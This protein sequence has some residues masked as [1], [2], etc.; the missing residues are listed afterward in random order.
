[1]KTVVSSK[2]VLLSIVL[3]MTFSVVAEDLDA[4]LEAQKKKAVRRVYSDTA[5]IETRDFLIP[6]TQSEEE[7]ALDRE[8]ERLENQLSIQV[9][10]SREIVAP[11]ARIPVPVKAEN[12]L[13]PNQ[14][15]PE[16]PE[17]LSSE[18]AAPSWVDLELE[19][20]KEIQLQKKALAEEE[21]LVNKMLREDSRKSYSTETPQ[22][23]SYESML[24]H[25]IT[26]GVSPLAPNSGLV[27]PLAS[28]RPK[29]KAPSS[30]DSL[31]SPTARPNSGVI[32]KT[33]F[34]SSPRPQTPSW[35]PQFESTAPST[36]T[37]FTSDWGIKKPEALS[38]LKRVRQSSPIHRKD[39]F[40]DD[41]MPEIKTSIWD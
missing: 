32:Q 28:L 2:F 41:F 35:K 33:S 39:P 40:A 8:L 23:K 1:M 13:T 31:F 25:T 11:R 24:R 4:A 27:D 29:E 38:P 30:S 16:N 19:R 20:Q 5:L 12:W 3:G 14:L 18:K 34:P 6:K 9:M 26:P 37:D 17:D 22:P 15:D 7:K 36:A 10:P 21:A